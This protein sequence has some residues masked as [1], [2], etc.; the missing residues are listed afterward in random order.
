MHIRRNLYTF[1]STDS[2]GHFWCACVWRS[3]HPYV[4]TEVLTSGKV[5]V[6][7][8]KIPIFMIKSR[9][10]QSDLG[11]WFLRAD[12]VFFLLLKCVYKVVSNSLLVFLDFSKYNVPITLF[13]R[14]SAISHFS[15]KYVV[16]CWFWSSSKYGNFK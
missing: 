2:Q 15:W 13:L 9:D 8:L 16:A 4:V 7:V 5:N 14:S 12:G 1:L 6:Q 3:E 11:G 10:V